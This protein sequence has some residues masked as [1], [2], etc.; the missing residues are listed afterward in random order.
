MMICIQPGCEN[1]ANATVQVL[2]LGCMGLPCRVL[3][4]DCAQRFV[5]NGQRLAADYRPASAYF[6]QNR[7]AVIEVPTAEP[8][9]ESVVIGVGRWPIPD[10]EPE[11]ISASDALVVGGKHQWAALQE[12]AAAIAAQQVGP[13]LAKRIGEVAFTSSHSV[14]LVRLAVSPKP[15]E[16]FHRLTVASDELGYVVTL[17]ELWGGR[18]AFRFTSQQGFDFRPPHHRLHV[19]ASVDLLSQTWAVN[20]R[21]DCLNNPTLR[22]PASNGSNAAE[23][24]ERGRQLLADLLLLSTVQAIAGRS[25]DDS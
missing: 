21:S 4:A 17:A 7:H 25:S 3:C 11:Q 6:S 20:T 2:E 13:A 14:Q 24:L 15:T 19:A 8:D 9:T 18:L 1:N 5:A 12:A 10:S 16:W 22:L 23:L